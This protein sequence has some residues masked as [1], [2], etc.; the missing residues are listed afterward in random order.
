MIRNIFFLL[1]IFTGIASAQKLDIEKY[2]EVSEKKWNKAIAG[3]SKKNQ[4]E[5]HPDDSILF[6]GSSSIRLW[7]DIDADMQPY[8]AIQYRRK[9]Q[10]IFEESILTI[11]EKTLGCLYG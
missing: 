7:K 1:F 5:K 10:S 11:A 6:V 3:F 4:S 2:R 8:H 9:G